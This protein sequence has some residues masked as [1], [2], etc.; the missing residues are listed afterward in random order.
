MSRNLSL[1]RSEAEELVDLLESTGAPWALATAADIREL[2]G[3]VSLDRE[4][5]YRNCPNSKG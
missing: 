4:K 3:M 2:F 5:E 1:G